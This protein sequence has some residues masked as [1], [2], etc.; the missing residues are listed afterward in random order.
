MDQKMNAYM[1][2]TNI[3]NRICDSE[4]DPAS[5]ITGK[6]IYVTHIQLDELNNTPN[7]SRRENL[8]KIFSNLNTENI[9]TESAAWD[10]SKWDEAQWS[11]EK[12]MPTQSA[13]LG[14]SRVGL[15]S[16]GDGILYEDLLKNLMSKKKKDGERNIKDALIAETCIKNK[17][18]FITDDRAL[19]EVSKDFG[20]VVMRWNA[21]LNTTAEAV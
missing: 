18:I 17:F 7:E 4:V 8:L 1:F 2:D 21:F 10:I 20:C 15:C 6:K 9:P 16:L 14:V 3:F 11:D 13:V 5:V 19:F 12:I